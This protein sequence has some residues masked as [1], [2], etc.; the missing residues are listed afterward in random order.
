[1]A[2]T[3]YPMVL[4]LGKLAKVLDRVA[5]SGQP[6]KVDY[7]WLHQ[8]GFTSSND[9]RLLSALRFIGFVDDKWAPTDRWTRF[10]GENGQAVLAEAIK[11]GYSDLYHTYPEAHT[12]STE[13][14]VN[15]VKAHKGVAEDTA[16]KMVQTFH[17]LATQAG[18]RGATSTAERTP[19]LTSPNGSDAPEPQVSAGPYVPAR[20]VATRSAG[21]GVTINVNIQL[22]L[23]ES[24]DP[25]VYDALFAALSKHILSGG[26]SGA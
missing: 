12:E 24:K 21:S 19:G 3:A 14:L 15:Y 25:D 7:K 20:G 22:E 8:Y 6:T 16:N 4:S 9:R 26:G 17:A 10:R 1:M 13:T 2:S 11:S 5:K 18:L 23:P